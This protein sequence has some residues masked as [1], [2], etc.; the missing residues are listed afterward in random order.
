MEKK[1]KLGAIGALGGI[2]ILFLSIW[3][4]PPWETSSEVY[5]RLLY[6]GVPWFL[7]IFGVAPRLVLEK[8]PPN[9]WD[10][11]EGLDQEKRKKMVELL[12]EMGSIRNSTKDPVVLALI[13]KTERKYNPIFGMAYR[14]EITLQRCLD[15][16]F[17]I[18]EESHALMGILQEAD[19]R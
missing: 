6:M 1:D 19:G 7:F 10:S 15:D 11:G 2:I 16:C 3:L 12:T 4:P 9:L 14:G 8:E 13:E 5:R 18:L 17:E